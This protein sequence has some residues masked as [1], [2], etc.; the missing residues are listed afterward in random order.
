MKPL[1]AVSLFSGAGG[2]DL[3]ARQ[4]GVETVLA[5]ECARDP[6]ATYHAA[7]PSVVLHVGDVREQDFTVI[8]P[9]DIV[10]GSPPCQ[11]F[12][13]AAGHRGRG[14]KDPRDMV[15]AFVEAIRTM[16]PQAFVIENVPGLAQR[17]NASYWSSVLQR[18]ASL[19]YSVNYAVLDAVGFGVAQY[20]KRLFCVGFADESVARMFVWPR[21]RDERVTI[22][23]VLIGGYDLLPVSPVVARRVA[24]WAAGT[25]Y[26]P[27]AAKHEVMSWNDPAHTVTSNWRRGGY[28][29]LVYGPYVA[30][31]VVGTL[32]VEVI[33][34]R[35]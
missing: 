14:R 29:G 30:V 5:V 18:L 16:R 11:P 19:G 25:E 22:G 2:L 34:G 20:R 3:G 32:V 23:D 33:R 7:F 15:P 26:S 27:I 17:R 10:H 8:G 21:P 6:A 9:V 12:S 1:R 28:Y 24:A 4:T 35:Q 13:G 31:D